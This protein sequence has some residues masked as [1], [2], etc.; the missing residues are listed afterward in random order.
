[1]IIFLMGTAALQ[2]ARAQDKS[3]Y[4]TML[5]IYE[6]NDFMNIWGNGTDRAYTNGTRID[7]FYT[8][9]KPSRFFI[10][11]WMPR[12]GDSSVHVFGWG[13]MQTMITPYDITRT[14]PDPNDYPYSGA[15]FA[16][17]N[18]HASNPI[19]KY[20]VQTEL[21]MGVVGPP[22]LAREV[23]ET[24]HRLINYL[25][26]RGWD[27]QVPTDLL[28]NISVGAEKMLVQS[29]KAFEWI[30]GARAFAGTAFN[31]ASIHTLFRVGKMQPYF[32]GFLSQHS[33]K[34][35]Q[36]YFLFRPSAEWM[37]SNALVDG[38]LFTQLKDDDKETWDG[39]RAVAGRHRILG[40]L[41]YG[42]VVSYGKFALS[43]TQ[44]VSTRLKKNV[45]NTTFGNLS[46]YIAW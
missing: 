43:F 38:G 36:C 35:W 19:K 37:L 3:K 12:A 27:Y 34:G 39:E 8:K 42:A 31:G 23:Q 41:H 7:L 9:N 28:L 25:K 4:G 17:H 24:W 1:M 13:I 10:D 26:P 14:I 15:L 20:N 5:R 21:L 33:G 16:L 29:G 6:D 40:L 2:M 18:L 32:D 30:G 44:T 46:L 11:R 22:S 45:S